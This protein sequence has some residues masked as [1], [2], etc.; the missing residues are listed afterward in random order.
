MPHL[1][2]HA[3]PV[4]PASAASQAQI[5]TPQ[6]VPS[7]LSQHHPLIK[8]PFKAGRPP[9]EGK[10]SHNSS[11]NG[12][13]KK[14]KVEG[15]QEA[16]TSDGQDSSSNVLANLANL[17]SQAVYGNPA[18]LPSFLFSFFSIISSAAPGAN[19]TG[20]LILPKR[21]DKKAVPQMLPAQDA[22]LP[23][24]D[25]TK[26][27]PMTTLPASTIKG[28]LGLVFFIFLLWMISA[29]FFHH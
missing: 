10:S 6:A 12:S 22:F 17:A 3:Y 18:C 16:A 5:P 27:P 4:N 8:R 23:P 14:P 13:S 9:K 15:H 29:H 20:Q 2:H 1:A 21:D 24:N 28:T 25:K 7:P 19:M 26:G 11:S